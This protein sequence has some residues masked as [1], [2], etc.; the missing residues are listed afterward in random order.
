MA[1]PPRPIAVVAAL[2]VALTLVGCLRYAALA[3][4]TMRGSAPP[5]PP[6]APSG[7]GVQGTPCV[8]YWSVT[9]ACT[10]DCRGAYQEQVVSS[11]T[12][13]TGG[14]A[15]CGAE[16][17]DVRTVACDDGDVAN[18][19]CSCDAAAMTL[20]GDDGPYVPFFDAETAQT[21]GACDAVPSGSACY[22]TCLPS[23]AGTLSGARSIT[24]VNG[25]W[26][27]P[28]FVPS[29]APAAATCTAVLEDDS[30][31]WAP[32]SECVGAAN[33]DV[34]A[35]VCRPGYVPAGAGSTRATCSDG[36]WDRA[37]SCTAVSFD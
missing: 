26:A 22:I 5:P 35:V 2:L 1:G 7:R 20:S 30:R 4:A 29:C 34:C 13:A 16:V 10:G 12:E 17:G 32:G 24:C 33:G 11:V 8:V 25:Q 31:L 19:P 37:V 23:A 14:G 15:P 3:F 28:Q 18:T 36:E 21:C 27:L 6:S 9:T